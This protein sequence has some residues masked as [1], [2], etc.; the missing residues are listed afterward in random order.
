MQV[1]PPPGPK[2]TQQLV[3]LALLAIG[4]AIWWYQ[5]RPAPAGAPAP[6]SKSEVKGGA[7][8][9]QV[10]VPQ[11]L[12]LTRLETVPVAPEAGRNLFSFGQKPAPIRGPAPPPPPPPLPLPP[13]GPPA[14]PPVPLQLMGFLVVR[15]GPWAGQRKANLKDP[16]SGAVQSALEG[17]VL[18]G[19]YRVVK[20]GLESVVVEYVDGTGRRT[21]TISGGG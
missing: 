6:A 13:P 8:T 18:D 7:P 11:K 15:D 1:L 21:I 9:G 17:D 4:S 5:F 14:V 3:L 16:G 20:V 19:R 10:V 12:K 2:R